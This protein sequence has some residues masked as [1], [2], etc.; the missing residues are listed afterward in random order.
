SPTAT[1][2]T[3][4][5]SPSPSATASPTS[6]PSPSATPTVAAPT[7]A[8]S[9]DNP[10]PSQPPPPPPSEPN[11]N[12]E[13][14]DPEHIPAGT[15]VYETTGTT[16]TGGARQNLPSRTELVVSAPSNGRQTLRRD[17]RQDNGN[18]QQTTL[19]IGIDDGSFLLHRI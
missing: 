12:L 15:Y 3:I 18:G 16:Q 19:S 4:T 7:A 17:L 9:T 2:T 6:T 8:P 13:G 14:V 11:P 5:P 10:E 1:A